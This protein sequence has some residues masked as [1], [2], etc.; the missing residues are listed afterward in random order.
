[1]ARDR[2]Q[3]EIEWIVSDDGQQPVTCNHGQ[4]HIINRPSKSPI[5]SFRRNMVTALEA[6]TGGIVVWREDDDWYAADWIT[7]GVEQI[8]QCGVKIFGESTARYYGVS[9]RR[10]T[11]FKQTDRASLA[12]TI[13]SADLIPVIQKHI[14][15]QRASF[16]IDFALWTHARRH[17]KKQRFLST[18]RRSVGI[19]GMPGKKNLGIGVDMKKAGGRHDPD[20]SVLRKWIGDDADAYEE[21]SSG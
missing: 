7:A 6:V 3:G 11:I 12:Q 2:Y 10:Y 20:G 13:M 8:T 1:M 4:I 5:N 18:C 16:H 14:A 21:F 19:K 15:E 17:L 9:Q